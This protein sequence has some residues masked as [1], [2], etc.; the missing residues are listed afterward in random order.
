MINFKVIFGT[1]RAPKLMFFWVVF[2][3]VF[4]A[5]FFEVL[6]SVLEWFWHRFLSIF[7]PWFGKREI[8]EISTSCR[9]GAFCQGFY[10]SKIR[11]NRRKID[12]KS[13]PVFLIV[14]GAIFDWFWSILGGKIAPKLLKKSI[15]FSI[16]FLDRSGCAKRGLDDPRPWRFWSMGR[17]RGR[18]KPSPGLILQLIN[19]K[20]L[21]ETR[22]LNHL[23]P[24]GLVGLIMN[25]QLLIINY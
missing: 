1:P 23:T 8:C 15:T 4:S 25:Y 14:F 2:R 18:G 19:L 5:S 3:W 11:E 21:E 20:D 9:R 12:Q 22:T 13:R 6:R 24:R 10:S 16:D 7:S 17:G